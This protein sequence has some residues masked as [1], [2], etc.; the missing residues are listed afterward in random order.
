M[1]RRNQAS[2]RRSYGRRLHE[3]RE[4]HETRDPRA[5]SSLFDDGYSDLDRWSTELGGL[6]PLDG[7]RGG[8]AAV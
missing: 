3:V 1:S 7:E 5:P 2:R 8:R 6:A 4:R